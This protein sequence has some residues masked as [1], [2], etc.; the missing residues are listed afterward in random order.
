MKG[1]RVM[2]H[3]G[4]ADGEIETEQLGMNEHQLADF[5]RTLADEV[6]HDVRDLKLLNI[7]QPDD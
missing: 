7:A 6:D 4:L 2:I 1:F 3:T 5:L